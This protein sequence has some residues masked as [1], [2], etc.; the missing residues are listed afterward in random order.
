[1][2]DAFAVNQV[3]AVM[4]KPHFKSSQ[5]PQQVML[6]LTGLRDQADTFK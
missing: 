2:A 6:A 3:N 1:M 4:R 5:T